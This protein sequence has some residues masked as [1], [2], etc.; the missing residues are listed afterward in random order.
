MA[1]PVDPQP[2]VPPEQTRVDRLKTPSING[3]CAV[4]N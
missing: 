3:R 1:L 4:V 2:E